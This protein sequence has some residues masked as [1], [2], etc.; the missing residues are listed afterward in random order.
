MSSS[1]ALLCVLL[2]VCAAAFGMPPIRDAEKAAR[3]AAADHLAR[4]RQKPGA[5]DS[6]VA[7]AT[8]D[9]APFHEGMAWRDE[10][11]VRA[12]TAQ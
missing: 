10:D 5:S 3:D 6:V 11:G 7:R 1:S 12:A 9:N 8:N 2:F 4:E